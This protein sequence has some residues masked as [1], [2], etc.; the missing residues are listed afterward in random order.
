MPVYRGAPN[1][2]RDFLPHPKAVMFSEEYP[3]TE[4][5]AAEIGRVLTD[6]QAW[7]EYT[8]WRRQPFDSL[9]AGYRTLLRPLPSRR[10]QVC[11]VLADRKRRRLSAGGAGG[12]GTVP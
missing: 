1:A 10:C 6:A 11:Q 9:G 5:L 7:E 8:A 3:S 12:A 2:A 4:A